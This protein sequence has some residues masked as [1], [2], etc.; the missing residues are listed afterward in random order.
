MIEIIS[1]IRGVYDCEASLHQRMTE[2]SLLDNEVSTL[3][4]AAE[5]INR[6][7][8]QLSL[9]EKPSFR[10]NDHELSM[11]LADLKCLNIVR[12]ILQQNVEVCHCISYI[13][14][15]WHADFAY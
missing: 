1:D 14:M 5:N 3:S 6:R 15:R 4:I 9:A 8:S 12:C 11:L 2:L 13:N 7:M 10:T